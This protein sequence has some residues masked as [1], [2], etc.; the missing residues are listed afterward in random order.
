[1]RAQYRYFNER[2]KPIEG[3]ALNA[4]TNKNTPRQVANKAANEAAKHVRDLQ[5]LEE[6]AVG[7]YGVELKGDERRVVNR[8][9]G[10]DRAL[11]VAG[12]WNTAYTGTESAMTDA[13]G[14]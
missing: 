6:R 3:Q 11:S 9:Y 10:L 8:R 7:T 13:A 14:D 5:G 12:A 1:T 4:I 2:V